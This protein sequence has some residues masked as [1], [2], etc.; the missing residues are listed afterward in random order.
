[1]CMQVR[2]KRIINCYLNVA[3]NRTFFLVWRIFTLLQR[4]LLWVLLNVAKK[5][6]YK[7][8]LYTRPKKPRLKS[9]MRKVTYAIPIES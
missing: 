9:F 6:T 7:A 1:M 2:Q 3:Q 4:N 8:E 5:Q